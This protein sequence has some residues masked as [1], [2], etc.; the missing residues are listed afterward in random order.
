MADEPSGRT[1]P[2]PRWLSSAQQRAWRAYMDGHQR[3]MSELNRQLQRDSDLTLPEY[4]IL[5]LL[6]ESPD[7]SLRIS[8]LADGVL[9]SRSR[10]THQIRR[11]EAQGMVR[12]TSTEED[13]RGVRAHLTEEGMRRLRAAAPGHVAAV[14]RD[15]I[16][17][18][19]P[20]QLAV[21]AEVFE[22]VDKE[23]NNRS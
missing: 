20:E 14:R 4:R 7:L 8:D 21:I 13:G 22:R 15:F 2:V 6:S 1:A 11:M 17:L 3:L 18:L 23:I 5:V 9:S 12:R 19:T 10:L 16:D